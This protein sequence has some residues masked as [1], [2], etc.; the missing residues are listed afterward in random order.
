M[1]PAAG[2]SRRELLA[3]PAD[4]LVAVLLDDTEHALDLRQVS[5]FTG[6]RTQ[7]QRLAAVERA[8]GERVAS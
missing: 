2:A 3:G 4:E 6:V 7:L 8:T 5:P 1:L